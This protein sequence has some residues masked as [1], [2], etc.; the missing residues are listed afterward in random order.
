M[1]E[2]R[3]RRAGLSVGEQIHGDVFR[4]DGCRI[5]CKRRTSGEDGP[6]SEPR[7]RVF[8]FIAKATIVKYLILT[9]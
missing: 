9:N 3:L 4:Y 6:E 2:I 7:S 8:A 5:S 1:E